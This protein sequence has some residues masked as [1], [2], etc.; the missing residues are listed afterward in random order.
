MP[1]T[2][3]LQRKIDSLIE[4]R[5]DSRY[6]SLLKF[7][8]F[9]FVKDTA[10]QKVHDNLA[11]VYKNLCHE[12]INPEIKK[13][14]ST[15]AIKKPL[16]NFYARYLNIEHG[17]QFP[18]NIEARNLVIQAMLEQETLADMQYQVLTFKEAFAQD[19]TASSELKHMVASLFFEI[20]K[21]ETMQQHFAELFQSGEL[22][23][24]QQW[25]LEHVEFIKNTDS[26]LYKDYAKG[27]LH[28]LN[29]GMILDSL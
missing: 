3:D 8:I 14:A 13:K 10:T 28:K 23:T 6:S 17:E 4:V 12:T 18:D 5:R 26:Y 19:K 20:C 1:I 2:Q 22:D 11:M 21:F 25:F 24:R 7:P 15:V 9:E 16:N 27:A 29:H